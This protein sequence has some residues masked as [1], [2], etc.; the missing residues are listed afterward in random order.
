MWYEKSLR[1]ELHKMWRVLYIR[2]LHAVSLERINCLINWCYNDQMLYTPQV[3]FVRVKVECI[4]DQMSDV[5]L[6]NLYILISPFWADLNSD[7]KCIVISRVSAYL[8]I[9]MRS[10]KQ[11]YIMTWTRCQSKNAYLQTRQRQKTMNR[12]RDVS[13]VHVVVIGHVPIMILN[14][15]EIV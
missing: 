15:F 3:N 10:Q 5:H 7:P 13:G 14:V 6:A 9:T 1:Q 8:P 2:Y 11:L 12:L 4:P